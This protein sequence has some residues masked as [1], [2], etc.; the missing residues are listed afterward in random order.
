MLPKVKPVRADC[1]SI[2]DDLGDT[3]V[4]WRPNVDHTPEGDILREKREKFNL[5]SR[6]DEH[7]EGATLGL[8]ETERTLEATVWDGPASPSEAA[9]LS[10]VLLLR[11]GGGLRPWDPKSTAEKLSMSSCTCGYIFWSTGVCG[12]VLCA[13]E[14]S[15]RNVEASGVEGIASSDCAEPVVA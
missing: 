6:R 15:R 12:V 5:F 14:T 4:W 10:R 8:G 7:S 2:R 9:R 13:S 3:P 11:V 1:C